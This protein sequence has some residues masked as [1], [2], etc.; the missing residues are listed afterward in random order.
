MNYENRPFYKVVFYKIIDHGADGKNFSR[1]FPMCF[2]FIVGSE[3]S[4]LEKQIT[5]RKTNCPDVE[6]KLFLALP[7]SE[8]EYKSVERIK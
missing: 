3:K 2:E 5:W 8:N 6:V 1:Y 4:W 7:L